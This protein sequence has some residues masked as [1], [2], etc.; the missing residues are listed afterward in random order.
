LYLRHRLR[1]GDLLLIEEP[2]A[3][4]HPGAQV[5]FAACLVRLIGQGLRVCLTTH[6]EFFLQQL[7]NAIMAGSLSDE[8]AEELGVSEDRI[9]AGKVAAYFFEPSDSGTAVKRLPIEQKQ[10][11]PEASFDTVTD[12]LYDQIVAL[13]R[14]IG[15]QD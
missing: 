6:S 1:A 10:G 9:D 11:I 3:H 2:E 14:R 15:G 5:A 12:Q 8:E 7:N 4:L 13:D